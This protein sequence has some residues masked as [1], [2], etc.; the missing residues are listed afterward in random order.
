[1]KFLLTTTMAVAASVT[2]LNMTAD[3]ALWGALRP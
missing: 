3:A 2:C 1:M